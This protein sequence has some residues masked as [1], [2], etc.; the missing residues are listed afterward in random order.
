MAELEE[1]VEDGDLGL[2]DSAFGDGVADAFVHGDADG[3]VEVFLLG[4]QFDGVNEEG[5]GR[6]VL[7]YFV[8]RAAEDEGGEAGAEG[9]AALGVVFL[10]DGGLVAGAEGGEVAEEAGDEEVEE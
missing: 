5:F 10:F 9:V 6:K 8:L 1:G 3:F 7:G 4:G 2:G